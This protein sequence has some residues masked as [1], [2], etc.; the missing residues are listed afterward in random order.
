MRVAYILVYIYL[1]YTYIYLIYAYVRA[2]PV[3]DLS[4]RNLMYNGKPYPR[5]VKVSFDDVTYTKTSCTSLYS[6]IEENAYIC[7]MF[8]YSTLHTLCM[9][10]YT[11]VSYMLISNRLI[12]VHVQSIKILCTYSMFI[13]YVGLKIL[14]L[15]VL[16]Y[17]IIYI[18]TCVYLYI[19][20]SVRAVS[21]TIWAPPPTRP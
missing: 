1:I 6:Y 2:V 10:Y 13:L 11:Y 7:C 3:E 5:K 16:F 17:H 21:P 12:Y 4:V 15:Y 14:F 18:T 19:Y 20:A 8:L 9:S